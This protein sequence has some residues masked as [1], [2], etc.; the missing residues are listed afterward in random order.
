MSTDYK[1]KY[2]NLVNYIPNRYRSVAG[3][4]ILENLHNKFLTKEESS[5]ML[6]YVGDKVRND[7]SPYVPAA[8][9]D[10]E[11]NA[12]VPAMYTKLGAE[13]YIFTFGDVLQKLKMLGVDTSDFASWGKSIGF[14]FVPPIDLDKF[15]NYSRYRWYGHLIDTTA[16]N[17]TMLPEYYVIGAGGVSDWSKKNYWVHELDVANLFAELGLAFT[18]DNTVQAVRPIIEYDVALEQSMKLH[19]N[20]GRPSSTGTLVD[21]TVV[22][23]KTEFNQKPF[24]NLYLHNGQHSGFVS[25]IFYYAEG[26]E[27]V[28]DSALKSRIAKDQYGDYTFEQGLISKDGKRILFYKVD[29]I[30]Q[31]VWKKGPSE[32]PK[33]FTKD[34]SGV[35]VESDPKADVNEAGAWKY[36]KQMFHNITHENRKQIGYG[37]L[38]GHFTDIIKSQVGFKGNPYG[39]NNFRSLATLDLGLGGRIKDYNTNFSLFLG[40]V[41]Q[42]DS[43]V[44]SMIEF[45][46]EQY[47]QLLN[48]ISEFVAQNLGDA[49]TTGK[50]AAPA[51]ELSNVEDNA[52]KPLLKE[53]LSF[54]AS[55]NDA[56]VFSD[57][58][59]GITGWIAT[60]PYL[61][62]GELVKPLIF[63][64]QIIGGYVLRHHDTHLT[65]IDYANYDLEKKIAGK[66]FARSNGQTSPGMIGYLPPSRPFK[67]HFWFD[68][69]TDTLKYFAVTSD[70]GPSFP[71][72]EGDLFFDRAVNKLFKYVNG[73]IVEQPDQTVAWLPVKVP[74][75][76][77]QLTLMVENQLFDACPA[78]TTKINPLA[79]LDSRPAAANTLQS[80]E[81][82]I[83]AAK[84]GLDTSG[85]DYDPTDAFTW[86]YKKV[87]IA[88][89]L[90]AARWFTIYKAYF[91][92]A[93]PNLNPWVLQGYAT[94]PSWWNAAYANQTG[95]RKWS[96]AM[97][98]DIKNDTAQ[99]PAPTGKWTKKLGVDVY[100]DALLPPYVS[101][102]DTRSVEALLTSIPTGISDGYSFGDYGPSEMIW[103]TSIDFHYDILKTAFRL[104]PVTFVNHSWGYNNINIGSY[105]INRR[106]HRKIGRRDYLLHGE[107]PLPKFNGYAVNDLKVYSTNDKLWTITC[108]NNTDRGSVFTVSGDYSG[109][110]T[111][112]YY[113][114]TPL[115]S[116]QIRFTIADNSTDFNIGDKLLITASGDV[117]YVAS[118][119]SKFNGLNQWFVNL[120]RYNSVDMSIAL[121]D[122]I[123]RDWDMKLGYRMSGLV[124]TELLKIRT[125][126]FALNDQAYN[127]IIKEN[128]AISN[129]WLNAIRIQLIR[130]GSSELKNGI[131]VPTNRGADWQFRI[132]TFNPHNPEIQYYKY[133]TN[134]AYLTFNAFEKS[135]TT[136]EWKRH[137]DRTELVTQVVP[138]VVTGIDKVVDIL[139]GYVDRLQEEGWRFNAGKQPLVD[140]DSGRVINW[141][142]FIEHFINQQYIGSTAGS[143][144][145]L[146]PFAIRVEFATPHGF[147]SNMRKVSM[148][149]PLST[150]T[151]FDSFGKKI[152]DADIQIFR[153]DTATDIQSKVVIGGIHLI[154]DECE[155]IVLFDNYIYD[156]S[157]PKLIY[158]PFLGVRVNRIHVSAERQRE[159]NG[160]LSYGGHYIKDHKVQR[161][162]EASITDMLNYYDAD[163]MIDNSQTAKHARG[164]LGYESKSYMSDI[165]LTE[166]SQFG[167]WRGLISN[168]GSNLSVNAF[169]NSARFESAKID[170][171]WAYKLAEFGDAR[172]LSFPEIKMNSRDSQHNFTKINFTGATQAEEVGF[173]NI[174]SSDE[175]RWVAAEDL[176]QDVSFV[177]EK[178]AEIT[179]DGVWPNRV[180]DLTQNGK[181]VIADSIQVFVEVTLVADNGKS[182]QAPFM[183]RTDNYVLVNSSTI[184]FTEVDFDHNVYNWGGKLV[185]RCFGP[186][187]PKFNP[188]KLID[189]KNKVIISDLGLWDPARGAHTPEALKIVDMI[190]PTDPAKFNYSVRTTNNISYD[191]YRPWDNKDIGR[192]WWNTK[193]L[194]YVPYSDKQIFPALDTRLSYWGTLADWSKIELYEWT[195]SKVHPSKYANLVASE[196]GD[197][198][199]QSDLRASGEVA[200]SELYSRKRTWAQRAIAWG[201]T[202]E[203]GSV[204]PYLSSVGE[205]RVTFRTDL[206]GG[207]MA[208][209]SSSDWTTT[210]PTVA[211]GMKISGGVF[212]YNAED[213]ADVENFK[214]SQP[215]GEA[216]ITGLNQNIVIGSST[217]FDSPTFVPIRY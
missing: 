198:S 208:I 55:R 45:A 188:A 144:V 153:S 159:F 43:S 56:S 3:T 172:Q 4:S 54:V 193:N 136:E 46:K 183:L 165:D 94:M 185:V 127:V 110:I 182:V 37:D 201:Y 101:S 128:K 90:N 25:S 42:L 50:I 217:S 150:Q 24:F 206:S 83:Y 97:W 181:A 211:L 164:L 145:I 161:N 114:N 65:Y 70:T 162:I 167:F 125:D 13:E 192:V 112:K 47:S 27:Y 72:H 98:N 7:A 84:F 134:G 9:V 81:L 132:E 215:F 91:G 119:Y 80:K 1:K 87:S 194:A 17:K 10:R 74:S 155:H 126:Q 44:P 180:Y 58:T 156:Q 64:D 197:S 173:I 69:N 66:S 8:T 75:I 171:F 160:R 26:N 11:L 76:I 191:Q 48:S 60:I 212:H 187:Q 104:D 51:F 99:V 124:N 168:K 146:N 12:L 143:G 23:Y 190:S 151:I 67:N 68:A 59:S 30:L 152:H 154:V 108:V 52:L 178:I 131:R 207:T 204:V 14:N 170:E 120:N 177:A 214:L 61:G 203:P 6:G 141:Q 88:G 20:N 105:G 31:S 93:R 189:Y 77:A 62:L 115:V 157:R 202:D 195:E 21:Q 216:V 117:T 196:E 38:L 106:E 103:R 79:M 130:V 100:T 73:I 129:H 200:V 147:V 16:Y 116:A 186:S 184:Q 163:K 78:G 209:L 158:D 22:D 63:F 82:A 29:D 135:N 95:T 118:K 169:L 133:N 102:S 121:A 139:F 199:I 111:K 36:P 174:S 175:S 210:F 109:V 18:V 33:Y 92:T 140:K 113:V 71:L 122:N 32:Q 86:N 205:Y 49:I 15:T 179:F 34:S 148:T 213:I 138:F 107:A 89:L 142:M 40:L 5:Q 2:T 123:L 176:N 35:L 28:V 137:S 53:F 19:I 41:N 85:G 166:K 57:T 39:A 96:N 149:D